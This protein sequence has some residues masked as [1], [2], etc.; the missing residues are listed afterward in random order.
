[1]SIFGLATKSIAPSSSARK[2]TSAPCWVSEETITTGIGRRRIRFSRNVM[3]SMRGISTSSV[4]TSGL[5]LLMRSRAAYGS[6]AVPTTSISRE[7]V[8]IAV[9]SLRTSAE[10]STTRTLIGMG[11][12]SEQ[13]DLAGD[14]SLD[15]PLEIALLVRADF[16][17]TRAQVTDAHTAGAREILDVPRAGVAGVLRNDRQSL[18]LEELTDESQVVR[19]D[20][21]QLRDDATAAE[22][23]HFELLAR[24]A[25]AEHAVDQL[26]HRS[27][28]VA[29]CT[30]GDALPGVVRRAARSRQHE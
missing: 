24:A 13:I 26:F 2:V 16:R 7:R 10:S 30:A 9:R 28:A 25:R 12:P 21:A 1:M 8:S 5:R 3:P 14:G 19:P 17:G 6:L 18:L 22:D 4:M 27:G 20:V 15:Q 29:G 23:L 11:A